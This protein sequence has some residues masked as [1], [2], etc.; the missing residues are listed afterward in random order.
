[1]EILNGKM[2]SAQIKKDVAESVQN[3]YIANGKK[4]PTLACVLVGDDPASKVYVSNKEKACNL[5]GFNSV[6]KMLPANSTQKEVAQVIDTLNRDEN[7]SG[8]LL[9]LPLPKHLNES[10]LINL[11]SPDKDVDG[12]T[13]INIGKLFSGQPIDAPCTA[14]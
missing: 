14:V 6:I 12:L 13:Y 10:E 9:Q 11:I 8:I 2:V 4:V 1:M 5:V 7:V 3:K